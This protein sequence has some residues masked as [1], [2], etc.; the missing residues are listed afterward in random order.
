MV[1]QGSESIM[2]EKAHID[3]NMLAV[4]IFACIMTTLDDLGGIQLL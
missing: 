3:P 1:E 4:W 2:S